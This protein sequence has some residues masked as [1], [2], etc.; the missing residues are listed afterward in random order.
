[1]VRGT[2]HYENNVTENIDESSDFNICPRVIAVKANN[3]TARLWFMV[4]NISARLI[5]IKPKPQLCSPEEVNGPVLGHHIY[6]FFHKAFWRHRYTLIQKI[7]FGVNCIKPKT[8]SRG[9]KTWVHSQT[10]NKAQW[11]AVCGHVSASSQSLRFIL[12]L[13]MYSSFITSRP[14]G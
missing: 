11:L 12:S 2:S 10:Q 13:S 9:Y 6:G 3:M 5:T 1:M 14:A 7:C 8:W 4:C